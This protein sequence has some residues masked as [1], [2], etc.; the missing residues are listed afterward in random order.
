MAFKVILHMTSST[1]SPNNKPMQDAKSDYRYQP[2]QIT[3]KW[4]EILNVNTT[5]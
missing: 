1:E 3:L 4:T 5:M 2:K